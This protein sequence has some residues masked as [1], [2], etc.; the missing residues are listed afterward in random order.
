MALMPPLQA[1]PLLK[2]FNRD[3]AEVMCCQGQA[4]PR[5]TKAWS[6]RVYAT[7]ALGEATV[8]ISDGQSLRSSAYERSNAGNR[9]SIGW[10]NPDIALGTIRHSCATDHEHQLFMTRALT[11]VFILSVS[12][13]LAKAQSGE[14]AFR[15]LVGST[16]A[17]LLVVV[18]LLGYVVVEASKCSSLPR[19]SALSRIG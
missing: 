7:W 2:T 8:V 11:L 4:A 9:T 19:M 5:G 12:T 10:R 6:W 16:T 17:K 15:G 18:I 3:D 13:K 14:S 1:R